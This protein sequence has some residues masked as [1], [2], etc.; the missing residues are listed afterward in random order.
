MGRVHLAI[1][2]CRPSSPQPFPEIRKPGLETQPADRAGC[3]DSFAGISASVLLKARGRRVDEAREVGV[4][5]APPEWASVAAKLD[6]AGRWM[7]GHRRKQSRSIIAMD[8]IQP[9]IR[10]AGKFD[11]LTQTRRPDQATWSVETGQTQHPRFG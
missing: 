4:V 3:I 6:S 1:S 10:C 11:A 5:V 8:E 9:S 2:F 7:R